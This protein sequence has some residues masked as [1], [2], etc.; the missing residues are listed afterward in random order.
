L[1]PADLE[2][3]IN[4]SEATDT[5]GPTKNILVHAPPDFTVVKVSPAK[6]HI[7]PAPP[8]Q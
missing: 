6:A 3:F 2:V 8:S 5:V 1:T 4:L 7:S